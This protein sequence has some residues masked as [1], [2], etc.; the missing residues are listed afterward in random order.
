MWPAVALGVGPLA[1]AA[2]WRLIRGGTEALDPLVGAALPVAALW[3]ASPCDRPRAQRAGRAARAAA[4]RAAAGARRCGTR[5]CTG[6]SSTGSSARRPTGSRPTT[7]RTIRSRWWPCAPRP[8]TSAC[9]CWP[10]S[11]RGI[12]ASSRWPTWSSAWSGP[13][14]AGA[15]AALPRALLQLVRPARPGGAGAG[16]RLHRGQRQP[17]G[18]PRRAAAGAARAAGRSRCTTG[19]CWRAL[20]TGARAGRRARAE[21][22]RPSP[23]ESARARA[24]LARADPMRPGAALAR[25]GPRARAA[26]VEWLDWC[27]RLAERHG[28]EIE[29][30]ALRVVRRRENEGGALS[31][32]WRRAGR[33]A[34]LR[35]PM[36][37]ARLGALAEQC[38]DDRDGDGLP[39]PLRPDPQAVLHRLPAGSADSLDASYYDLLASEAR[40]ASFMAVAKN[41]VPVEHWF[42]LGRTLTYAGGRHGAGVVEREHVR[43]PDAAAGDALVSLHPA[44]PD[45]PRRAC[46]GR[47]RTARSAGALGRERERLQRARPAPHLSVPRLRRAGPGAQARAGPGPR[48]RAV[49]LGARGHGGA[50]ERARQS[51][52]RWR[53]WARSGP[54]D[55]ATRSTTPA[56]TPGQ[57]F[58]VVGDLHGP[59]HR[60]G[61]GRAHQR[62]HR[63]RLWQ[64]RFHADPLVR[65]AELLLHE[66]IPRRLVLQEPQD[67]RA[68]RGAARSRAG[69]AGGARAGHARTPRRP[70]SRCWATCPTP[71]W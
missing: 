29:G 8:P 39:L 5:C 18:P 71:S 1:V 50:P 36:L 52:R 34:R 54:T 51:R 49:R 61:P 20:A 26:A 33:R 65:S 4:R 19:G 57:P 66:R 37:L 30:V 69:A 28:A 10:R 16:L 70:T 25:R 67:A 46:A 53:S 15:D 47:S 64:R 31:E 55:S 43:V 23:S 32:T 12:W 13:S 22:R 27:R 41:E 14:H 17:G 40:L 44:R 35:L 11:A 6:A 68:R 48:G 3:M 58:A 9:S 56:P 59:P 42:R 60:H 24:A 7:S 2:V 38:A 45:L 21:G 62:A 63:R